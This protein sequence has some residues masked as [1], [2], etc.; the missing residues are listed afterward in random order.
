MVR[1]SPQ[2][3]QAPLRALAADPSAAA[4]RCCAHPGCQASGE[5]KAPVA[6]EALRSYIWFCL[7][8]VRAYNQ[9]WDYFAGQGPEAVD[10][11]RRQDQIWD[12]PTWRIGES[13]FA[14][15]SPEIHDGF[16]AFSGRR[17]HRPA[18]P[19]AG[20]LLT[21]GGAT[22]QALDCLGLNPPVTA[23]EVKR[24]YK[25]LAKTLHPDTNGGSKKAEERL[26][27]VNQAYSTLK[28]LFS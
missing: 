18:D 24:R 23:Q 8:H 4:A 10:I 19:G 13:R 27:H 16:S 20:D 22:N 9:A 21:T 6:R 25:A 2:A 17:R 26:K 14:T 7:D 15:E 12:R 11:Q 1:S 5:F 3:L 28:A